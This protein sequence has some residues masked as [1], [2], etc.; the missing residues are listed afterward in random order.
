MALNNVTKKMDKA[1]MELGLAPGE[2]VLMGC[3]VNPRGTTAGM[4]IG[5][6]AGMA[7]ANKMSKGNAASDGMATQWPKGRQL[8]AITSSRVI[9]C[10]MSA[11]AGKPKEIT[12]SW[13]HSAIARFEVDKGKT[14]YPFQV[15]FTDGSIVDSEG[16]KGSGADQLAEVTARIWK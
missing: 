6:L 13:P 5:G 4:A 15:E 10:K 14:A 7:I 16:A 2:E 1:R 11:M 3:L 8:F 12:A 9:I